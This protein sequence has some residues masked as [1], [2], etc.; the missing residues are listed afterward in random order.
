MFS[1]MTYTMPEKENIMASFQSVAS[2]FYCDRGGNS[3]I[4]L[5]IVC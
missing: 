4:L 2:G 5:V 3:P 1:L